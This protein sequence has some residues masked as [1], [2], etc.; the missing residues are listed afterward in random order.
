MTVPAIY[1]TCFGIIICIWAYIIRKNNSTYGLFFYDYDKF[2]LEPYCKAVSKYFSLTGISYFIYGILT[3]IYS[4]IIMQNEYLRFIY[5]VLVGLTIIV[6]ALLL[7]IEI[8]IK[9]KK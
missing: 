5:S 9:A 7:V 4:D 1:M 6:Y 8:E 2:E 3:F